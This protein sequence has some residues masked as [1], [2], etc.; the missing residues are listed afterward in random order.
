MARIDF[1]DFGRTEPV[2]ILDTIDVGPEWAHHG[3][4]TALLLQLLVN[5]EALQVEHLE[6]S[7]GRNDFELLRFLYHHGFEPSQRIALEKQVA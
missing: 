2:A 7:V 1:G 3:V 4:A 6:T 5:L